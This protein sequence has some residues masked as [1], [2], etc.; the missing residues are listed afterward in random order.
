MTQG[1]LDRALGDAYAITVGVR[2][3]RVADLMATLR[4]AL[5]AGALARETVEARVK[6]LREVERR[7]AVSRVQREF[8]DRV[9]AG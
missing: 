5:L 4:A 6:A 9:L 2:Q 1:L 8:L 7:C 3:G